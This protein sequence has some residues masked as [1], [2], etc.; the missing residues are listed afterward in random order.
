MPT[1]IFCKEAVTDSRIEH[2]LPESLGGKDWACLPPGL[3]CGK[4]NQYFG[5][6]V[7]TLALGSFPFQAFRVLLGIPT[8]RGRAS[9]LESTVGTIKGSPLAGK[10][11]LDPRSEGIEK[12]VLAG[13]VTQVRLL[14]EPT[15][16]L[17]VC[18][19]LLKM[20]L[21]VVAADSHAGALATRFDFARRF[22]RSP[23]LGDRWW[24]L[25]VCNHE[26]LFQ[27]FGHG[28]TAAEWA[29]AVSLSTTDHEGCEVFR[30][31]LLDMN[32]LIP[33]EPRMQPADE[34]RT[35][36]PDWRVFEVVVG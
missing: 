18:R 32:M 22:A 7:E 36:E 4:C 26:R 24:Y 34:L 33:L 13:S 3:V 11:G 21:E 27:R 12:G 14:A 2:I 28:V 15:E 17:A 25:L 10:I 9:F 31:Q 16:S 1:C 29:S 8:K 19:L 6:K 5:A 30:L 35:N 23:R 20:G